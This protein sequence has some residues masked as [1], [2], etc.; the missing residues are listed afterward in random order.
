MEPK[1]AMTNSMGFFNAMTFPMLLLF[2]EVFLGQAGDGLR[3]GH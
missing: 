3:N 1:K 2:T